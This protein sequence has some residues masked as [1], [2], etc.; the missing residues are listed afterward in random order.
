MEKRK[1][2]KLL[3]VLISTVILFGSV[4]MAFATNAHYDTELPAMQGHVTLVESTRTDNSMNAKNSIISPNTGMKCWVD[5]LIGS[6]PVQETERIQ[7]NTG[8]TPLYYYTSWSG[9]CRARAYGDKWIVYSWP[10]EGF[11]NFG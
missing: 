1:T 8:D 7:C 2:R 4:S 11:F 3:A 9:P 5:C 10:V 6:S